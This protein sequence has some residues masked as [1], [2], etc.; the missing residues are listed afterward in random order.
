MSAL[1]DKTAVARWIYFSVCDRKNW[2]NIEFRSSFAQN[3]KPSTSMLAIASICVVVFVCENRGSIFGDHYP[4]YTGLYRHLCCCVSRGYW[5]A[6]CAAQILRR[7]S[8]SGK[9]GDRQKHRQRTWA[10]I[11][12]GSGC[13]SVLLENNVPARCCFRSLEYSGFRQAKHLANI[14]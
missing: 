7:L 2:R 6:D 14:T 10:H 3:I 5:F 12:V 13:N 8:R 11:N 9:H 4:T 1:R